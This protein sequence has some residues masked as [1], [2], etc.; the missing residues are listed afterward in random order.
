ML[1][2]AGRQPVATE[3]GHRDR[4]QACCH[5]FVLQCVALL[6]DR[7]EPLLELLDR[8]APRSG[9]RSSG[10]RALRAPPAAPRA[11]DRRAAA[12]PSMCRG[13]Q[14]RADLDVRGHEVLVAQPREVQHRVTAQ[15]AEV[16]CLAGR[17]GEVA[18]R[19]LAELHERRPAQR[20]RAEGQHRDAGLDRPV[21][22]ALDE[23]ALFERRDDAERGRHRDAG[24]VADLAQLEARRR[25]V[26]EAQH[27]EPFRE[28]FD[29]VAVGGLGAGLRVD[30]V[31]RGGC[32]HG[33]KTVFLSR[34]LPQTHTRKTRSWRA[35]VE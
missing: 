5:L 30:V 9:L 7:R 26:E 35:R 32:F 33:V 20:G 25:L 18:Q 23:A 3:H 27:I 10:R 31:V 4:P 15:H 1:I 17:L 34:D 6:A 29:A 8:G 14:G 12:C 19:L 24:Q 28:R 13:R 21:G 11:T 22:E 16:H 2:A